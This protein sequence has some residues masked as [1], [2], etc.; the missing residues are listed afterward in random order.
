MNKGEAGNKQS[1][2][3]WTFA[4]AALLLLFPR[5]ITPQTKEPVVNREQELRMKITAPFTLVAVGDI[6]EMHPLSETSDRNVQDVIKIVRNADVG[7]GNMES[8]M[9]DVLH[10]DGPLSD[11][12]G[13][14]EVA[15]DVKAMGFKIVNRANNHATDMG[16][17]GMFSTDHWLEEAGVAYAGAGKNLD[18][19]RAARFIQTPKGR[20][21]L[22]GIFSTTSPA[23]SPFR[24]GSSPDSA[25]GQAATYGLGNV[26]LPGVN[27]LHLT[28]YQV[29]EPDSI[30][31][32]RQ[33]RDKAYERRPEPTNPVPNPAPQRQTDEPA[34]QVNFFGMWFKGGTTPGSISYKMDPDDLRQIL[35]SI[36]GG[37]EYSDFTIATIHT[38]EGG[39]Y[40]SDS[41][42]TDFLIELAHKAIDNGADVFVGHGVHTLRGIEIYKGK[43]IF[44]GLNSFVY[45]LE[46]GPIGFGRYREAKVNPFTT[47]ETEA[48]MNLKSWEKAGPDATRDNMESVIA[49]CRY[50]KGQLVEVLLYPIDLGYGGP[51][52]QKGIPRIATGEASARIL[53]KL[54][55]I[56]TPFGTVITIENNVGTIHVE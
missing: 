39:A 29:M 15:A 34:G 37:K 8:N 7:F 19:A 26:G 6:I 24:T 3:R 50:D 22:V 32:L 9:V 31:L 47:D 51:I 17:E 14:K 21:S 12:T 27:A 33:I 11:H 10:Y 54:Q 5:G 42:P 56:S 52:S 30:A 49:G 36:R 25:A 53:Q 43:P 55:K 2:N 4:L 1:S 48:E 41:Y 35:R 44:Y 16:T 46:E 18:E 28:M 20:V 23:G 40:P 38:H 45:Q 13:S